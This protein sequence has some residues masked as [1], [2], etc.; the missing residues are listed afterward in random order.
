MLE[1]SACGR[2]VVELVGVLIVMPSRLSRRAEALVDRRARDDFVV[3][4]PRK[5]LTVINLVATDSHPSLLSATPMGWWQLQQHRLGDL[6]MLPIATLL[7]LQQ[8]K[9]RIEHRLRKPDSPCP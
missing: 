8:L 1:G 4:N 5:W 6:R 2:S 7:Q 3:Q 9:A